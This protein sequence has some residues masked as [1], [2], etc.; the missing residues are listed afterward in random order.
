MFYWCVDEVWVVFAPRVLVLCCLLNFPIYRLDFVKYQNNA[1]VPKKKHQRNPGKL[2][3]A[4]PAPLL[5][6]TNMHPR[7]DD[8]KL[9]RQRTYSATSHSTVDS[10]TYNSPRKSQLEGRSSSRLHVKGSKASAP[11]VNM[12]VKTQGGNSTYSG[13]SSTSKRNSKKRGRKKEKPTKRLPVNEGGVEQKLGIRDQ[14]R[15]CHNR[16]DD[17]M[18]KFQ[19]VLNK[20]HYRLQDRRAGTG[21]SYDVLKQI[22][23][24]TEVLT[25]NLNRIGWE[26]DEVMEDLGNW[27]A[28]RSGEAVGI[29]S[30]LRN[31]LFDSQER[32]TDLVKESIND[33][34]ARKA[35]ITATSN[36]L[37]NLFERTVETA[38]REI[39]E[40][41][42]KGAEIAVAYEKEKMIASKRAMERALL[43]NEEEEQ[44]KKTEEAT[45]KSA[46]ANADAVSK[47]NEA[48]RAQPDPAVLSFIVQFKTCRDRM[49]TAE[50]QIRTYELASFASEDKFNR[51]TEEWT[52]KK[53]T[54]EGQIKESS[55]A[56]RLAEKKLGRSHMK[57]REKEV[58]D[59]KQAE[60]TSFIEKKSKRKGTEMLKMQINTLKNRVQELEEEVEATDNKVEEFRM[61]I[62]DLEEK[63]E[64]TNDMV[65]RAAYDDIKKQ[66]FE[67]SDLVD[68]ARAETVSAQKDTADA[69]AETEKAYEEKAM[70]LDQL[71][72]AKTK[73][74]EQDAEIAKLKQAVEEAAEERKRALAEQKAQYEKLLKEEQAKTEEQRKRAEEA[75]EAA[76]KL[77]D[78]IDALE[79]QI[80]DLKEAHEA[81]MEALREQ[82]REFV[83]KLKAEHEEE[84]R[85]MEEQFAA[86]KKILEDKI[87]R[88]EQDMTMIKTATDET[89]T[90]AL[91]EVKLGTSQLTK[92]AVSLYG[93]SE[94]LR[95]V[96]EEGLLPPDQES[97]ELTENVA[98]LLIGSAVD[99]SEVSRDVVDNLA[100]ASSATRLS[101][102]YANIFNVISRT[103]AYDQG[104]LGYIQFVE[105][106]L[107]NDLYSKFTEQ[108]SQAAIAF[109]DQHTT[110]AINSDEIR[111]SQLPE[112]MDDD[113]DVDS[114]ITSRSNA[115][116][117]RLVQ[118]K[119]REGAAKRQ[120][121]TLV[122]VKHFLAAETQ[123]SEEA[124]NTLCKLDVE[125]GKVQYYLETG[126]L[127]EEGPSLAEVLESLKSS[128]VESTTVADMAMLGPNVLITHPSIP[129]DIVRLTSHAFNSTI[130]TV[131]DLK[132]AIVE[133]TAG[134]DG[135]ES[136]IV[137]DL[138]QQT[139][140]CSIEL[141]QKRKEL[142]IA[143]QLNTSEMGQMI[144]LMT[145]LQQNEIC[146]FKHDSNLQEMQDAVDTNRSHALDSCTV[147]LETLANASVEK[148][149]DREQHRD[150]QLAEE[151]GAMLEKVETLET[152]IE[153]ATKIYQQLHLQ[154]QSLRN[155]L[156]R[157][158]SLKGQLC[159]FIGSSGQLG[160]QKKLIEQVRSARSVWIDKAIGVGIEL[161][162]IS[163]TT[164]K[165]MATLF[166]TIED[167]VDSGGNPEPGQSISTEDAQ[168]TLQSI[169]KLKNFKIELLNSH[170]VQ[171]PELSNE[172]VNTLVPLI[173]NQ[174]DVFNQLLETK[175]HVVVEP[176]ED[177]HKTKVDKLT[178]ELEAI[179][180]EVFLTWKTTQ[181]A[182]YN[183]FKNE[184]TEKLLRLQE[185]MLQLNKQLKTTVKEKEQ[186]MAQATEATLALETLESEMEEAAEEAAN[187]APSSRAS[188]RRTKS[189]KST[190][191]SSRGNFGSL[192]TVA[193]ELEQAEATADMH[194]TMAKVIVH[195]CGITERLQSVAPPMQK[196]QVRTV[197]EPVA[198]LSTGIMQRISVLQSMAKGDDYENAL[199]DTMGAINESASKYMLTTID[200]CLSSLA[201]QVALG[202]W[203]GKPH[204]TKIVAPKTIKASLRVSRGT[205][206]TT[207]NKR[208]Q[209]QASKKKTKQNVLRSELATQKMYVNELEMELN[210]LTY[211]NQ[212]HGK[213]EEMERTMKKSAE[214][215]KLMVE[216]KFL[217]LKKK[218]KHDHA[219]KQILE[220]TM[221]NNNEEEEVPEKDLLAAKFH[222]RKE[223]AILETHMVELRRLDATSKRSE[224]QVYNS[225][226]DVIT[227]S[228]KIK[229]GQQIH[230]L[231][232]QGLQESRVRRDLLRL[233]IMAKAKSGSPS[234]SPIK[235]KGRYLNGMNGTPKLV[236]KK[237]MNT[238][239]LL[240]DHPVLIRGNRNGHT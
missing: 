18:T 47:A 219:K 48:L 151:E 65:T 141:Q 39:K 120:A 240:Y 195:L 56:L 94:R 112:S 147:L 146:L 196:Q 215:K 209:R 123:R 173:V 131:R 14:A 20:D 118:R 70:V 5:G 52:V 199:L 101:T 108:D 171:N 71:A 140:A 17:A 170:V 45:E 133:N 174:I 24:E 201:K 223:S 31:Q 154:A 139:M 41:V 169:Q 218:L 197:P 79:Q 122:A 66:L 68:Q 137:Q 161:S 80:I 87:A 21:S 190:R 40:G 149:K 50:G 179:N 194:K 205:V 155:E 46:N 75:E 113:I 144:D 11:T 172:D 228:N 142:A 221:R 100:Q 27:M 159:D 6:N 88:F 200:H 107:S 77:Q 202:V 16:V 138:R 130:R 115:T 19:E 23:T 99:L 212:G 178:K 111:K 119:A 143:A 198:E 42:K 67:A 98:S 164:R 105:G 184:A 216:K 238:T 168:L 157:A 207:G 156:S 22:Q 181:Q 220:E 89:I 229:T 211:Q 96:A 49:N 203:I 187:N 86:E 236:S 93:R 232:P 64:A 104:L 176:N 109:H 145:K 36:T 106:T 233:G 163:N 61:E 54:L 158:E 3:S 162:G 224:I 43:D 12:S 55:D 153:N 225:L 227:L 38:A 148:S 102:A 214:L 85:Q 4:A 25:E 239:L 2:A 110:I 26:R 135:G 129:L 69:K 150:T 230:S 57:A 95:K 177:E 15:D 37:Q 237:K 180:Q 8:G 97:V 192:M 114:L 234:L 117:K 28:E 76:A 231:S 82:H 125:C 189:R 235:N 132:I 136:E 121:E 183:S 186:A 166:G 73:I 44:K 116:E 81:A 53:K 182:Y 160:D 175:V 127:E 84:K 51:A 124:R 92:I 204:K 226:E 206:R 165:N 59:R 90:A 7:I 208:M 152:A 217:Y 62:Q 9:R 74:I 60:T 213:L 91:N 191:G 13:T 222:T 188:S 30:Q 29:E 167:W 103:E 78:K 34:V 63:L 193:M 210:A 1:S 72:K 35:L 185:E 32:V 134:A 83:E 10:E 126:G 33:M 58:R 128:R